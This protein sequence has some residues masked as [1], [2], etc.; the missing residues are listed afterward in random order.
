[1][2]MQLSPAPYIRPPQRLRYSHRSDISGSLAALAMM[3][4]PLPQTAAKI[5]F[6]VAPTL[7]KDRDT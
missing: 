2:I 1:M 3:V 7:G 6:S 4:V 5:M